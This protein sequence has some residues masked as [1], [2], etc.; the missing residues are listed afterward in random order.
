MVD[1]RAMV[2]K[3]AGMFWRFLV[4]DDPEVDAWVVRDSD[5]KRERHSQLQRLRSRSFCTRFG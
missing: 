2:G 1:D 3:I 4:A 5:R